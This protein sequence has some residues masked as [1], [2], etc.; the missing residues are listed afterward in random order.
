MKVPE[1]LELLVA[2]NAD[3]DST[4][5]DGW[6]ALSIALKRAVMRDLLGLSVYFTIP[7]S[8]DGDTTRS[9]SGLAYRLVGKVS[10][11]TPAEVPT[12]AVA[13]F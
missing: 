2:R 9:K 6:S 10:L 4:T 11:H 13:M 12:S 7:H 5:R 1:V 8:P 3:L